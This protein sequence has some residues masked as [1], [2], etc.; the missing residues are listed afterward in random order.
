MQSNTLAYSYSTA[1][2][3]HSEY[4][5]QTKKFEKNILRNN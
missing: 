4:G 3:L 5:K 1:H 2:N